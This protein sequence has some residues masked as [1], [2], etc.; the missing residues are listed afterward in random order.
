LTDISV[1]VNFIETVQLRFLGSYRYCD[2]WLAIC[3]FRCIAMAFLDVLCRSL[4]EESGGG[5]ATGGCH[6]E[7]KPKN[8]ILYVILFFSFFIMNF[9]NYVSFK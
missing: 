4:R 5:V 1:F 3:L 2:P 6:T 9:V 8:I 7:F